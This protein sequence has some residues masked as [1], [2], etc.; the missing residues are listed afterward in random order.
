MIYFVDT[1]FLSVRSHQLM[2]R[3]QNISA[4]RLATLFED[5]QKWMMNVSRKPDGS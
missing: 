2:A 1:H 3:R 5:A 4:E